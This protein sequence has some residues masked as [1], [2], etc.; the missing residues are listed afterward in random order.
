MRH[1]KHF[2][3]IY[4][5]TLSIVL[6][7]VAPAL[8]EEASIMVL[9]ATT[10]AP[11]DNGDFVVFDPSRRWSLE[12]RQEWMK[13]SPGKP[14]PLEAR[15]A[16]A[17]A[18]IGLDGTVRLEVAV[19]EPRRGYFQIHNA[20]TPSGARLGAVAMSNN[21]ILE[22]GELTVE[23]IRSD[24][25]IISGA[26]YN[27]AVI[28][29]WRLSEEY[30]EKQRE[31][32]RLSMAA[33]NEPEEARRRRVD[34]LV[35]VQEEI[36]Q[37]ELEGFE[38]VA[39]NHPDLMVRRVAI[40]TAWIRGPSML[41]PMRKLAGLTPDDP[42]SAKVLAAM[43]AS[44]ESNA[45]I[46]LMEVGETAVD[47]TG[48]TL[49][50]EDVNTTDVRA[51]SRYLLLEFWA[52]WCGPCRAEIPHMKQAYARFRD[53]GFEIVSFTVDDERED[54]EE[55]SADEDLPWFDLGIGWDTKAAQAYNAR[56]E[57]LPSNFLVDSRTGEIVAKD[58]RQ[59]KLDEKLEELLE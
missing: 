9:E 23:V 42:W 12:K 28:N 35:E 3:W 13:V 49:D 25:S 41:E 6:L 33:D 31:N 32:T 20:V 1:K 19:S 56:T 22:P 24:Y 47:F 45:R 34:R 7:A 5:W 44:F 17:Q 26:Y 21:F 53:K 14:M 50:G 29:S 11:R 16:I 36:R 52:S 4:A 2:S 27:D 39:R 40:G 48:E 37:F 51:D 43:E 59:H 15:G 10:V 58:L 46:D 8:A 18:P 54:W 55:A 57:G 38:D 30:Q